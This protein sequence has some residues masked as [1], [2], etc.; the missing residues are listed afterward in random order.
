MGPKPQ[1]NID[2]CNLFIVI[3][4]YEFSRFERSKGANFG[5]KTVSK[6]STIAI[7]KR[8]RCEEAW[9]GI[10]NGKRCD[11]TSQPVGAGLVEEG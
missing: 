6:A 9:E 7:E 5:P 4:E 11:S 1:E 10:V 3:L 2:F 8:A